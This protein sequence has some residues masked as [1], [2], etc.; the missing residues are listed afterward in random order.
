ML[1]AAGIIAFEVCYLLGSKRSS[2][3]FVNGLISEI[4]G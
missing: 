3:G 4:E 2:E 1:S